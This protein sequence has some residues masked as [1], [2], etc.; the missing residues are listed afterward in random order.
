SGINC[1]SSCSSRFSI[2]DTVNLTATPA[3]GSV[4]T[5]WSGGCSGTDP[6]SCTITIDN[7]TTVTATFSLAYRMLTVTKAGDGTGTVVSSPGPINCGN[8]C[9]ANLPINGT[10]TLTATPSSASVLFAGWS[11]ACGGAGTCTVTMDTARSVTATFTRIYHA[12]SVTKTG[13][14]TGRVYTTLGG[15]DCG[16][17]CSG[18]VIQGTSVTFVAQPA[19][20]MRFDGWTGGTCSG[21]LNCTV[22]VTA[23]VSVT[24]T[25][26]A[27][28]DTFREFRTPLRLVDTRPNSPGLL[29]PAAGADLPFAPN[30][31]RR[32][33]VTSVLGVP[34]GATV[35]LNVVAV[36]P[37][38]NGNLN[39]YPCASL[40][41]TPPTAS[42]M[43]FRTGINVANAGLVA[44]GS[45]G[46]ICIR[47]S[48][49]T[50]VVV[51]GAGWIPVGS[52]FTPLAAPVRLLDTRTAQGTAEAVNE[53][54]PFTAGEVRRYLPLGTGG[55]PA[56]GVAALAINVVAATPTGTG[57][58]QAYPCAT[59]ADAPPAARTVSF[60]S[61]ATIA[62]GGIVVPDPSGGICIR[63][64]AGT[65]VVIDT[66]GYFGTAGGW[67]TFEPPSTPVRLLDTQA[68]ALGAL[69]TGAGGGS[70]VDLATRLAAG[71]VYR[72]ALADIAGFPAAGSL[73]AVALTITAVLPTA[74]GWMKAWA[75]AAITDPP[76][77]TTTFNY[78]S[79]ITIG[80]LAI[81]HTS[82]IS[83]TSTT[84]T[85]GA[86]GI[87]LQ[88]LAATHITLDAT[89][90][91]TR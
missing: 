13:T 81:V 56:S 26:T 10:Y 37:R 64:T 20:G 24:A 39:I 78:R 6:N 55:L 70:G 2:G 71:T 34:V 47:A 66:A 82:S 87:C 14:G 23:P 73:G 51:D 79:G 77:T 1:G 3:T 11:G 12:L 46:G 69:E 83:G 72:F 86:G 21:T 41:T 43:N 54:T 90:W 61:G 35:H 89:G 91:F 65:H 17:T 8:T 9:S 33:L 80:N 88:S 85:A 50:D 38:A 27:I 74:N 30:T 32:Y 48:A 16:T 58:V 63:A 75:C 15:V 67:N 28:G 57:A 52:T 49:Q 44:V 84:G 31:T 60:S 19:L 42:F 7:T 59:L 22:T 36:N 40:S 18:S 5:G 25:F 29:D 53:T 76:P 4:F 68:G 62:T 45:G